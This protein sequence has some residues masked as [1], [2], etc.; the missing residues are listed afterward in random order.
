MAIFT[1]L[2]KTILN[3]KQFLNQILIFNTVKE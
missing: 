1:K 2:L 3:V